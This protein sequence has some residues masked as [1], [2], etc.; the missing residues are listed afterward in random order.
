MRVTKDFLRGRGREAMT[1]AEK[2]VLESAVE[3]IEELPARTIV[4]RRGEPV[5]FSTLLLD[6]TMCRYMDARDGF[7]QL[8]ALQ[9]TGDFVDLHGYPLRRLDHD[10]GTLTDTRV[11]II[12]HQRI[13]RILIEFP[14]LTRLLWRS[15][16]LD[17]ALHREWIFR[18]GRLDAAGRLA[19]FLLETYHR[20]RVV[21]RADG[22]SFDFALTQQ[23][24]GEALGLTSVHV[25]RMLRR[26]REGGLAEFSRGTVRILDHDRLA[27]IGEFDPDYLYLEEGPWYGRD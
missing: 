26:L 21:G 17:A 23:D 3:R 8:V 22:G 5:T 4:V 18:I 24:L 25:N 10:V 27:R 15:T 11:A 6:G 16:L 12:P 14:H 1:D 20:L 9:V 2:D 7:R 13:D 19:H